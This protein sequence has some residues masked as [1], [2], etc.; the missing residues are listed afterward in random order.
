MPGAGLHPN[1][2]RDSAHGPQPALAPKALSWHQALRLPAHC[3]PLAGRLPREQE[4]SLPSPTH[5]AEALHEVLGEGKEPE[6]GEGGGEGW[7]GRD[8]LGGR[9]AAGWGGGA[10]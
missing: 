9:Q 1:S 6:E 8:R 5:S 4:P 7:P 10:C 2:P 3:P